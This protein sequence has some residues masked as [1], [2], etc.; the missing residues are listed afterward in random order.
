MRH[1]AS[2]PEPSSPVGSGLF[3][4][5]CGRVDFRKQ[6]GVWHKLPRLTNL[7]PRG[8]SPHPF[9]SPA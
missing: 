5:L 9:Q 2:R 6:V 3:S 1:D 7:Y 4:Y 8:D